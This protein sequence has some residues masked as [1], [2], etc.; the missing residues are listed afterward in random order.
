MASALGEPFIKGD[1]EVAKKGE[2]NYS[3]TVVWT[4]NSGEG[5]KNY[6]AF[7]RDHEISCGEKPI[8][9]GSADPAFLGDSSRYN[10]EE[11][12]LSSLSACHMLWYLHLCADAGIT[13]SSYE[14]NAEGRMIETKSGG[15][16]FDEVILKPIVSI[17]EEDDSELAQS[18]HKKA[19]SLC[20]IA[21]SVNFEVACE[22]EIRCGN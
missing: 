19:H 21:N 1:T 11:L 17:G 7:S 15:G 4:G 6:R 13:V 14:D 12:L 20:F 5:T 18:L 16:C 9:A 3:A 10:P 8:I 2:H 22:P